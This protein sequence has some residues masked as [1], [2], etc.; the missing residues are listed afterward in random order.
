MGLG[1]GRRLP[2]AA[3]MLLPGLEGAYSLE[4]NRCNPL[5]DLDETR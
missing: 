5:I 3:G 4:A 1:G 2:Q